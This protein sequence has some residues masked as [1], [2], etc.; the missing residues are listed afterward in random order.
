MPA[1]EPTEP[2]KRRV[3]A[4]AM[5]VI[6]LIIVLYFLWQAVYVL[7]LIFAGVLL[8]VL[9]RSLA[10]ALAART[11]LSGG[12]SLT[13]VTLVI[14]GLLVA[15]VWLGA[16]AISRQVEQLAERLPSSIES[17]KQRVAQYKW[18]GF[19]VDHAPT[20]QEM[21]ERGGKAL[22]RASGYLGQLFNALV[23]VIVIVFIGLYLA[24]EPELYT[25]G[26]LRLVPKRYREDGAR[27]IG[28]VRYTLQWWLIGQGVTMVVIGVLTSA[29]LWLIGVPLWF[30]FGLL[31][32]LFN[33]IPN[34]G[35]LIPYVPAVLLALAVSP[36]KAIWVTVLFL[37]AQSFEGYF[38]TPM[39][40]RKAVLLPPAL[41]I[42]AQ[43]L[44]GVLVGALGVML[45][46]PL[47]AA[48]LV[49]V[50]ML[51]VEETLGDEM[52]TPDD[53]LPRGE[54]PPVPK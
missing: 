3:L 22:W 29:G 14:L 23:A 41:T 8:A 7:L 43:V 50:K 25:K 17:L 1:K 44:L 16:P 42:A 53:E 21:T 31:A 28:S 45:A 37:G 32:A 52:K 39:V 13:V 30:L 2:F 15:L 48:A 47:T 51:Y 40:Q 46:A 11:G 33:F 18:G 9:L 19:F 36:T 27:V 35:P 12:W 38:L 6:V 54:L 10:D 49:I 20:T 34:F 24:A 26:L 4:G 5:I